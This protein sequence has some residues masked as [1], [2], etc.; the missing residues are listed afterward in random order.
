MASISSLDNTARGTGL[1]MRVD[2]RDGRALGLGALSS[3]DLSGI[4]DDVVLAEETVAASAD[5]GET[6]ASTA[7][8]IAW[9]KRIK[10][11]VDI[12]KLSIVVDTAMVDFPDCKTREYRSLVVS[13]STLPYGDFRN[14][15]ELPRRG[16]VSGSK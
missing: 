6:P 5:T 9:R 4:L 8:R 14:L 15:G 13:N 10:G 2:D 1:S 11:F 3:L 7:L 16:T 12:S